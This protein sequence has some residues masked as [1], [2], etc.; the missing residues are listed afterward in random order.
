MWSG[1][2]GGRLS[3][4]SPDRGTTVPI[5]YFKSGSFMGQQQT[6]VNLK[7][8]ISSYDNTEWKLFKDCFQFLTRLCDITY[9]GAV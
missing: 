2:R 9:F 6:N 8:H 1:E 4:R 3:D 5:I 7:L